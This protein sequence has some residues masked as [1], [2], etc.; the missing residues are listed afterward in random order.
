MA[1]PFENVGFPDDVEVH[2]FYVKLKD[3]KKYFNVESIQLNPCASTE[4]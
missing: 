4:V 3:L 1:N 2:Y